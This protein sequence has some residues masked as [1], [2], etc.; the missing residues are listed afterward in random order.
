M[1]VCVCVFQCFQF[2][3]CHCLC[4]FL[5]RVVCRAI[6]GFRAWGLGVGSEAYPSWGQRKDFWIKKG[7][8]FKRAEDSN[9]FRG[10][11][12]QGSD[13]LRVSG[14]ENLVF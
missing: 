12:A 10:Q 6:L 8:G 13:L 5:G 1:Y 2:C 14:A 11:Q 3:I 7:L 4:L 9:E